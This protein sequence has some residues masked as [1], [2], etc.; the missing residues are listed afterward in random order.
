MAGPALDPYCEARQVIVATHNANIPILGDAELVLAL[1][2]E[3]ARGRVLACGGLE[4]TD[5]AEWS[6]KI[7]E[8]GEAAFAARH[9]RYQAARA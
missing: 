9:R 1:D 7:L 4:D 8:G 3:A 2:A 5:V 6:R